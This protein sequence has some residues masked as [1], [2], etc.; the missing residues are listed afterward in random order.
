M[1]GPSLLILREELQPFLGKKVLEATGNTT[2][3]KAA[4]TGRKLGCVET[5]R[6]ENALPDVWKLPHQ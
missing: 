2:Q 1:E 4:L 5:H 3:P 6:H